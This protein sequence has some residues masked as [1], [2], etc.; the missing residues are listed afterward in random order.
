MARG[1]HDSQSKLH[2]KQEEDVSELDNKLDQT[3]MYY[4]PT[5]EHQTMLHEGAKEVRAIGQDDTGLGN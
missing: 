2:R 3:G 4:I 5:G 1:A